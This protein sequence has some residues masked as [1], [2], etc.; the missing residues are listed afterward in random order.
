VPDDELEEEKQIRELFT[1]RSYT[2]MPVNLWHEN[3]S[4]GIDTKRGEMLA[5][6][7]TPLRGTPFHGTGTV[8]ATEHAFFRY[9]PETKTTTWGESTDGEISLTARSANGTAVGWSG[10]TRRDWSLLDPEHVAKEATMRSARQQGAE[11]VEP[12][13]YTAIF[14][15]TAV[16][17]LLYQMAPFFNVERGGPFS[18]PG[19]A[20]GQADRRGQQLFDARI[21][22]TTDPAD[23]EGGDFPFFQDGMGYP[24]GRVTWFDKGVLKRR[25]VDF[26]T[27]M[28]YG[29]TPLCDPY[30]VRM[31]GGPTS[32]EEMIAQCERG[33]YVHR[34]SNIDVADSLSGTMNGFTRDGCLLIM[35]GKIKK[36]IKDFRFYESPFLAFNRVIALGIPER[37][38]FGFGSM[39]PRYEP[40]SWP[41]APIIAPPIMVRDFNFS[42]LADAV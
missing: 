3:T 7:L 30:C 29:M 36:P 28:Q 2:Y 32:V 37:V 12:G 39:M 10:E 23:P 20:V 16:G 6:L 19:N 18:I 31:S 8:A 33:I 21:T 25:S 40:L 15:S 41:Y 34:F 5:R 4:S 27:G 1:P 9:N 14:S 11:R 26:L 42:A 38:A 35:D 22:L 24:S 17:Q 13:R